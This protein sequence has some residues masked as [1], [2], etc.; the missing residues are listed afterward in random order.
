M[1]KDKINILWIS[2]LVSP[3]GFSRVSHSI[4]NNLSLSKYNIVGVGVNYYGDPHPYPYPIF[5]AHLGGDI[6][7]MNRIKSLVR[8]HNFDIIFILNDIWVINEYLK[9]IKEA[10]GKNPIPKIVVYFPVDAER[11]FPIWYSNMD[12]VTKAVTYTEFAKT[13]ATIARPDLSLEIIP[14]GVDT[15]VF[16]KIFKSRDEAKNVLFEK[17]GIQEL[18]E[19]GTFIF[20]NANR[21]QPRKRLEITLEAFKLF[22]EG[23]NDTFI[24][25]HCGNTDANHI[26]V[27]LLAHTLGL[28][29][30]IIVSGNNITGIQR[31]PEDKLNLIYNATD[32]GINTGL[33]EGWGLPNMEHAVTG[34]PQIVP[35]HSACKELYLDCGLLVE[36][37]TTFML[38]GGAMTLG[39]LVK[40][41]DVAEA[42]QKLYV[43]RDLYKELS[44]KSIEKFSSRRY[45]WS[46]IANTWDKLFTEVIE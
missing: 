10:Y 12:M 8:T 37:Y 24:Y 31:F 20:L 45:S 15:K 14:H 27:E 28:K 35:A 33:G 11:H 32:V 23:K 26:N 9:T 41:E 46:E 17:V 18:R 44:R 22:S 36:P 43:D 3:T 39:K 4:L 2:D 30:K 29:N 34:A 1:K 40:A 16:S 19:P 7:G 42:M 25:M 21:N 38:D 6:Y 5:P 13:V